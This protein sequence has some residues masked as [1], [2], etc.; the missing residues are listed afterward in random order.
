MSKEL[1][2][3]PRGP[4][5]G[6]PMPRGAWP[7]LPQRKARRSRAC[8]KP[9][10]A[11]R[12]AFHPGLSAVLSRFPAGIRT[13]TEPPLLGGGVSRLAPARLLPRTEKALSARPG[14][15]L[16]TASV[17]SGPWPRDTRCDP[18]KFRSQKH[19]GPDFWPA[20]SEAMWRLRAEASRHPHPVP[21][22]GVGH[23]E[24]W[25]APNQDFPGM[26]FPGEGR[27][28]G[29]NDRDMLTQGPAPAPQAG[30]GSSLRTEGRG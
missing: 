24:G 3:R 20:S 26:R 14:C 9:A 7:T 11:A 28:G 5:R 29:R 2:P 15:P 6:A 22:S 4:S 27:N 8:Q 12:W 19:T 18:G 23:R 25:D 21:G 13:P 10:A 1:P 17:V 30:Q 16:T